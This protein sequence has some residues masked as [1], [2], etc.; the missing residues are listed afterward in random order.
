MGS[1]M[2]E[3]SNPILRI[4]NTIFA[5]AKKAMDR[6]PTL[7]NNITRLRSPRWE[8]LPDDCSGELLIWPPKMKKNA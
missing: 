8:I 7:N 2:S 3:F 4:S 5:P 1:P 6:P